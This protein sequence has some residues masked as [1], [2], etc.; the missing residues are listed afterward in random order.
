MVNQDLRAYK[1]WNILV[2]SAPQAKI[3]T[4][5]DVAK[6]LGTH[7]RAIRFVLELIQNYC[8]KNHL[9]PLTILVVNK[10][11]NE[12]GEGF[13][14]WSHDNLM[15][16]RTKVRNKDWT[17]EP[18]PFNY[19]SDGTTADDLVSRILS[20]PEKTQ[21]VYTKIKVRGAKQMIFRQALLSAYD[22][23][24]AITGVSFHNTLDAA[25]IIPWSQCNQNMRMNPRNGILM[26]CCHHRLFDHG[27]F[28]IDT[29]YRIL[30]E[31]KNNLTLTETDK[32]FFASLHGKKMSL[33]SDRALWPDKDFI[34]KR[35]E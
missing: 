20:E 28:S 25:H 22:G 6:D 18:N 19:A 30:F 3:I 31:N 27:I 16:G 10:Q 24:C 29:D 21:D 13:I 9:P 32:S 7:P 1:T 14:A 34:L 8:L 17:K 33:P 11:T 15:E 26:L 12:P 5:E 23:R 4:Y 35:N 2:K